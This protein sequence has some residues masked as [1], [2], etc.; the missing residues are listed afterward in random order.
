MSEDQIPLSFRDT[1]VNGQI[2]EYR[3]YKIITQLNSGR[4]QQSGGY[5]QIIYLQNPNGTVDKHLDGT[6]YENNND[7]MRSNARIILR[8]MGREREKR[9]QS[10]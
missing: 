7:D 1:D 5:Q 9:T 6:V 8:D 2:K 10:G 4:Y 3:G